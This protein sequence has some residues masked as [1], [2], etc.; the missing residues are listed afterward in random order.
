MDVN[1]Y[2]IQRYKRELSQA[3]D[4]ESSLE[5]SKVQLELDW[6]NRFEDLERNQYEKSEEL[7]KKLTR[8]KDEVCKGLK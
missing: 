1:N 3:A 2:I 5:R 6:Q 4:R 8:N 7:I